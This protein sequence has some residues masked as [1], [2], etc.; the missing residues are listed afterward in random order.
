MKCNSLH[1]R[2]WLQGYNRLMQNSLRTWESKTSKSVSNPFTPSTTQSCAKGN[3]WGNS[4][5]LF[6]KDQNVGSRDARGLTLSMLQVHSIV[7]MLLSFWFGWHTLHA[8]VGS[9]SQVI[10]AQYGVSSKICQ[11]GQE[12]DWI[13]LLYYTGSRTDLLWEDGSHVE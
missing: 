6:L 10:F 7:T 5:K 2:Q 11:W 12:G 1:S 13:V 4:L 9:W 8:E 3:Y